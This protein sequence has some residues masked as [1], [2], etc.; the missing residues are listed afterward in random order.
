M[1]GFDEIRP[2]GNQSNQPLA[3]GSGRMR[4]IHRRDFEIRFSKSKVTCFR[5]KQ[6]EQVKTRCA[7]LNATGS[8]G[9]DGRLK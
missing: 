5:H 7:L 8:G 2:W 3:R 4:L 9:R 1:R 6:S